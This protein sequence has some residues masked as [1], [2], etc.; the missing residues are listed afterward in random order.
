MVESCVIFDVQTFNIQKWP[1]HIV[2][3]NI[4]RRLKF[5][6]K[7]CSCFMATVYF[8]VSDTLE[9]G[10]RLVFC[11]IFRYKSTQDLHLYPKLTLF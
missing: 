5:L 3:L 2:Q 1:F 9:T 7:K 4:S 10:S 11:S 8:Y 6:F